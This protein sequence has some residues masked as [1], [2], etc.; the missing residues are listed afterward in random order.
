M[1]LCQTNAIL[2]SITTVWDCQL[3]GTTS[4]SCLLTSTSPGYSFPGT[5]TNTYP[6]ATGFIFPLYPVAITAGAITGAFATS[7]PTGAASTTSSSSCKHLCLDIAKDSNPFSG[8]SDDSDTI[9]YFQWVPEHCAAYL[10]GNFLTIQTAA[11]AVTT[12]SAAVQSSGNST[13]V[14][15]STK[16]SSAW[17]GPSNVPKWHLFTLFQ[18]TLCLASF[19]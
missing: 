19:F 16:V 4:A 6:V 5:V 13:A 18:A 2:L 3:Y 9:H 10:Y 17:S 15:T 11:T 14:A 7:Q 1:F 12:S 8:D